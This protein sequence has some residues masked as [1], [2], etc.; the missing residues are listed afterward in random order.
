MT[1]GGTTAAARDVISGNDVAVAVLGGAGTII[2][3]NYVGV[4]VTGAVAVPNKDGIDADCV[5]VTIGGTTAGQGNI[6]SGNSST[7]INLDG[8][9]LGYSGGPTNATVQGNF[10]G[11]DVN[12]TKAVPNGNGIILGDT[13]NDIIGGTGPGSGNIFSGNANVGAAIG[14]GVTYNGVGAVFVGPSPA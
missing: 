4:D 8:W 2:Q 13:T 3:G 5:G 12:G 11:T 6:V 10:V 1:I 7:G 9:A 14:G